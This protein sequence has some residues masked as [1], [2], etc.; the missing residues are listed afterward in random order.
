MV[1]PHQLLTHDWARDYAQ[2]PGVHVVDT[3]D[4][5]LTTVEGLTAQMVPGPEALRGL[6]HLTTT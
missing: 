5:L 1:L 2:R 3:I 6:A 4:D